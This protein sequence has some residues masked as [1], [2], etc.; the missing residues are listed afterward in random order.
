[1]KFKNC[2]MYLSAHN[3]FPNRW[4]VLF[5]LDIEYID[6][7]FTEINL[8][9]LCFGFSFTRLSKSYASELDKMKL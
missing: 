5:D 3:F 7:D 6:K 2:E 8:T 9:I 4:A 1:M